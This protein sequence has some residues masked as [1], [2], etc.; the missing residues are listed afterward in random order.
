MHFYGSEICEDKS[1]SHGVLGKFKNHY[2]N[3]EACLLKKLSL[4]NNFNY[5]TD[6]IDKNKLSSI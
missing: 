4:T 2:K 3:N 5:Y 6:N 1:S